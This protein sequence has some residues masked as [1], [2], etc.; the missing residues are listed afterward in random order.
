MKKLITL[1]IFCFLI[2]S[3]SK[4]DSNDELSS[5]NYISI[6][7]DKRDLSDQNLT[8]L[9][10]YAYEF[11]GGL[12]EPDGIQFVV[13]AYDP[14]KKVIGNIADFINN[15]LEFFID[16]YP[17]ETP[18]FTNT[19]S[20]KTFNYD[21]IVGMSNEDEITF[22][23]DKALISL[24]LKNADD[25]VIFYADADGGQ[26]VTIEAKDGFYYI[27]IDEMKFKN[28]SISAKFKIPQ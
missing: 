6:N 4:N 18:S 10:L 22:K 19:I 27:K 26:E 15:E 13:D 23:Y 1:I 14:E 17:R 28:T 9:E 7:G 2:L 20:F 21:E 16:I 8:E 24:R 5:E 12:D 11:N 3:C 25:D